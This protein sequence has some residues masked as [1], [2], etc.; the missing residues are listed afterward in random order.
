MIVLTQSGMS[1]SGIYELEMNDNTIFSVEPNGLR[2]KLGTY[3]NM[4]RTCEVFSQMACDGWD[5]KGR[6]FVMPAV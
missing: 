3:G 2:L 5:G 6:R 4:R 1:V